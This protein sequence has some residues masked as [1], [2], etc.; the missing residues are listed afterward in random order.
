MPA[1]CCTHLIPSPSHGSFVI[2]L[3][4]TWGA[5]LRYPAFFYGFEIASRPSSVSPWRLMLSIATLHVP[6]SITIEDMSSRRGRE[7][8]FFLWSQMDFAPLVDLISSGMSTKGRPRRPRGTERDTHSAAMVGW[9]GFDGRSPGNTQ[10][11]ISWKC[12]GCLLGTKLGLC[13]LA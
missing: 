3:V 1:S 10:A 4:G 11:L 12:L 9:L 2:H 7:Q 6:A 8:A 13:D 5:L